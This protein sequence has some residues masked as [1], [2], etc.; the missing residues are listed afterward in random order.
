MCR[1]IYY[2]IFHL[3]SM[4][5]GIPVA[6]IAADNNVLGQDQ[7]SA[8]TKPTDIEKLLRELGDKQ[9]AIRDNAS[10][11]LGQNPQTLPILRRHLQNKALSL[12]QQ[13]RVIILIEELQ[14]K[15]FK[16]ILRALVEKKEDATLDFLV[17]L[18]VEN[19]QR[20]DKEDW[21]NILATIGCIQNNVL[22]QKKISL[23]LPDPKK[24]AMFTSPSAN[25]ELSLPNKMVCQ[26]RAIGDEALE[27]HY[28]H[29]SVLMTA[30]SLKVPLLVSSILLSNG[31]ILARD[32]IDSSF[33]YCDEDLDAGTLI[34][35]LVLTR[36]RVNAK[37][38]DAN[39]IIDDVA[40]SAFVK[41]FSLRTIG[42]VLGSDDDPIRVKGV[43][44]KS[45][46]AKSG[47]RVGDELILERND[48]RTLERGMR[49]A[50][51]KHEEFVLRVR[52]G[53]QQVQA[54][55]WFSN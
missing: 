18:V 12:E 4:T 7:K 23:T 55:L 37:R 1:S 22:K 6:F 33:V 30:K 38:S 49:Q 42:L 47:L 3:A 53:D 51:A 29:D 36:G 5:I 14:Q 16:T 44:E 28:W 32:C 54:A 31:T 24:F 20:I 43:M 25:D 52:R 40:K 10:R 50:F 46:A 35:S 2:V 8:E 34:N 27:G 48:M 19:R 9:F 39:I 41:L 15:Q 11:Q 26:K 13:R 17:D 45:Q 21:K